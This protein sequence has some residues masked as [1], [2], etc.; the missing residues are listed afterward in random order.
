MIGV[1]G[2]DGSVQ[3]E[4]V[5]LVALSLDQAGQVEAED[6]RPFLRGHA[7]WYE[8]YENECREKLRTGVLDALDI[9]AALIEVDTNNFESHEYAD[10]FQEKVHR[11]VA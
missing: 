5:D 4:R 3:L 2:Q 6:G 11:Y 8:G 7:D 9:G 1:E 10:A